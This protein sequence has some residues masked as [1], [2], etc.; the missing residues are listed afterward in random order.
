MKS[1]LRPKSHRLV[2]Q[3]PGI[4]LLCCRFYFFWS[5]ACISVQVVL[6][7]LGFCIEDINELSE[8][9]LRKAVRVCLELCRLFAA[10]KLGHCDLRMSNILWGPQTSVANFE[11]AHK[12]P[13]K[14]GLFKM[15]LSVEDVWWISACFLLA[16]CPCPY[17][18]TKVRLCC[19]VSVPPEELSDTKVFLKPP[20]WK[21]GVRH[22]SE[23]LDPI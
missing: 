23:G 17:S 4:E 6:T 11:A 1:L 19:E 21:C 9:D 2:L 8:S 20:D 3:A 18:T 5:T 7:R 15:I 16:F 22:S 12:L 13:W 14:V 10:A